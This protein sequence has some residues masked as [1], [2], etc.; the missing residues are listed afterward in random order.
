MSQCVVC[1]RRV[2]GNGID[3]EDPPEWLCCGHYY[4]LAEMIGWGQKFD[5]SEGPEFRE[6]RK[7]IDEYEANFDEWRYAVNW[8][9]KKQEGRP[10]GR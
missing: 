10:L 9:L 8:Y 5:G 4:A 2:C 1:A 6:F 3:P 7:V